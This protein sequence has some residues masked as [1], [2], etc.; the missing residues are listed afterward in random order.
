M[1]PA[2][3]VEPKNGPDI[4]SFISLLHHFGSVQKKGRARVVDSNNFLKQL[5]LEFR[6]HILQ[7]E[8]TL[9]IHIA[10]AT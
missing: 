10:A 2:L 7:F 1:I 9:N 3:K 4:Y 8:Y 5:V 6:L